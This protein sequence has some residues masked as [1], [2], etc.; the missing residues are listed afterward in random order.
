MKVDDTNDET[1]QTMQDW[2]AFYNHYYETYG[3]KVEMVPFTATGDAGDEVAPG[4]RQHDRPGH[5]AL[6]CLGRTDPHPGLRRR[7]RRPRVL[8]ITCG[9]ATSYDYLTERAPYLWAL[10]ILP[11]QG[12]THVVEYISR[13]SRTATPST[14]QRSCWPA[15]PAS[16]A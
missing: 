1:N 5:Q 15:S 8:C 3:R 13:S 9:P 2:M 6:R 12:Q 4:R 11:E 16:S 7:A 14:R 10:G